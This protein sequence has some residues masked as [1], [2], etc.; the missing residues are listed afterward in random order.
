[1]P[2]EEGLAIFAL[3]MKPFTTRTSS[4]VSMSFGFAPYLPVLQPGHIRE[5]RQRANPRSFAFDRAPYP[6]VSSISR[7]AVRQ[8]RGPVLSINRG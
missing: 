8:S 2:D 1:M 5:R 7:P 3:S 4:K 6:V